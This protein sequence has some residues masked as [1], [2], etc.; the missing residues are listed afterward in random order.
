MRLDVSRAISSIKRPDDCTSE[1]STQQS[2]DTAVG[3]QLDQQLPT[4]LV[5]PALEQALTLR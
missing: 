4:E 1:L 3:W 2:T 5:L